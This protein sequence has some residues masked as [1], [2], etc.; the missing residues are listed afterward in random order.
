[1]LEERFRPAGSEACWAHQGNSQVT[2]QD[3]ADWK[4]AA[5][6]SSRKRYRLC[7]HQSSDS[8]HEMIICMDRDTY[9]RPHLHLDQSESMHIVEGLASLVFFDPQGRIDKKIQLGPYGSGRVFYHRTGESVYHT[10]VIE[11]PCLVVHET[12]AGPHR[13]EKTVYASWAPEEGTPEAESF[14]RNLRQEALQS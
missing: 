14:M 12:T 1:M 2:S 7:A 13:P 4:A 11:S 8:V 5:G 10:L 6:T 9:I 3:V